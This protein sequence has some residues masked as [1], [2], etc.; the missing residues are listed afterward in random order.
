VTLLLGAALEENP[1][2]RKLLSRDASIQDSTTLV[3]AMMRLKSLIHFDFE[4][5]VRHHESGTEDSEI[6]E[7]LDLCRPAVAV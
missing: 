6:L 7:V 2:P 4:T 3:Y 5:V 1:K